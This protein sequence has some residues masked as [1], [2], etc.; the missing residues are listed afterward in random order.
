VCNSFSAGDAQVAMRS[1]LNV[2]YH[3][4]VVKS[5][6]MKPPHIALV[7]MLSIRAVHG[8]LQRIVLPATKRL[9]GTAPNFKFP[10][11]SPRKLEWCLPQLVRRCAR[12]SSL[13]LGLM[14]MVV[15][16]SKFYE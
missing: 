8:R 1:S 12:R 16:R 11:R 10:C 3:M 13:C 15:S 5:I 2:E 4:K 7:E 6:K 14:L 9:K